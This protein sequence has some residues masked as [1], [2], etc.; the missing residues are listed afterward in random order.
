MGVFDKILINL[1]DSNFINK[2]VESMNI[3]KYNSEFKTKC[4][5]YQDEKDRGSEEDNK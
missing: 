3:N 1:K 4:Q 5:Q 2:V